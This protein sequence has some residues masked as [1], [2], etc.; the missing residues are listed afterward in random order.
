MLG[1]YLIAF[2]LKPL[3]TSLSTVA[4]LITLAGVYHFYG[5]KCTLYFIAIAFG[6][7]FF[8]EIINYI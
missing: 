7:M 2:R 5:M 4:S 3:L 8:L 1:G 6:G